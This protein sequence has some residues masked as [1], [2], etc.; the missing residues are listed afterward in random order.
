MAREPQPVSLDAVAEFCGWLTALIGGIVKMPTAV[1]INEIG[2]AHETIVIECIV[3]E[4]D[5]GRLL[6]VHDETI[7][8]VQ[9]LAARYAALRGFRVSLV[10][11]QRRG[12]R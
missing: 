6:G 9:R 10:V 5:T 2:R 3:D 1:S 11:P 4:P 12:R 7:A 8:L